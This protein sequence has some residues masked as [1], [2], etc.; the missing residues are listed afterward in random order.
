MTPRDTGRDGA[1]HE[2][3]ALLTLDADA[4]PAL[5]LGA[6]AEDALVG[7][8]LAAQAASVAGPS[9]AAKLTRYAAAALILL[10]LSTSASAAVWWYMSRPSAPAAPA[11]SVHVAPAPV[12][13]AQPPIAKSEPASAPEARPA[14]KAHKP[15]SPERARDV[16]AEANTLRKQAEYAAASARYAEA[17]RLAPR[18]LTAHAAELARA[19]LLLEQLGRPREALDCY[20]A[21]QRAAPGGPLAADARLGEARALGALG[22]A[23]GERRVLEALVASAPGTSAG[24]RA[25]RRLA[26]LGR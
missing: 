20:R 8:V 4:G 10:G 22:D 2:L 11:P 17:A 19:D 25:V 5:P 14:P 6:R 18:S 23:A 24:A 16:L 13:V 7:R 1:D 12:R 21:A 3:A 26:E 15:A 9:A